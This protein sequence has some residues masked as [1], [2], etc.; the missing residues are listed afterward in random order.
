MNGNELYKIIIS[1]V[2]VDQHAPAPLQ[3]AVYH[4]M[5]SSKF[6]F[7]ISTNI[8]CYIGSTSNSFI[9]GYNLHTH[10]FTNKNII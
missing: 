5:L 4:V 1:V 2:T 9:S 8:C 7:I 3:E 6:S 10:R